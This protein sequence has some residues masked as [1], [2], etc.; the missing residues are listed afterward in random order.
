MRLGR[1]EFLVGSAAAGAAFATTVPVAAE[2]NWIELP[3]QNGKRPLLKYPQK[4]VMIVQSSRPAILETPFEVF[5]QG[6]VTPNDAFFVRWHE[7]GFP[8][9]VDA[10]GPRS[11]PVRP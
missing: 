4:R 9:S 3:M 2:E 7:A 1:R 11:R 5:D 10:T 8:T 6:D